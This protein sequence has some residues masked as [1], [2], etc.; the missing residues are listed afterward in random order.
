MNICKEINIFKFK[1]MEI[2]WLLLP[3]LVPTALLVQKQN[4][5]DVRTI[6]YKFLKV[7]TD[8]YYTKSLQIFRHFLKMLLGLK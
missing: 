5:R 3:G 7:S 6:N 4:L 8:E 1:K 2:F